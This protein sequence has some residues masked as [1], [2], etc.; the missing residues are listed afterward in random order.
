MWLLEGNKGWMGKLFPSFVANAGN[1]WS[2]MDLY[3]V[4]VWRGAC[5]EDQVLYFDWQIVRSL[6]GGLIM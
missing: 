5:D 3:V 4:G 2:S 1:A 6:G